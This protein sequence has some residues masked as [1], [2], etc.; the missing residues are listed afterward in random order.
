VVPRNRASS[1]SEN[2]DALSAV[3]EGGGCCVGRPF[4]GARQAEPSLVGS[5]CCWRRE[6][7]SGVD[8]GADYT[9]LAV[10]YAIREW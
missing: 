1:A 3:A 4:P 2:H 8:I 5:G 7:A 6:I 10:T 9:V